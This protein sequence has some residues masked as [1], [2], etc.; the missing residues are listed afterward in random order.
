MAYKH[1]VDKSADSLKVPLYVRICFPLA[2]I[3]ILSSPLTIDILILMY[4]GL[5]PFLFIL[6]GTLCASWNRMSNPP[7]YFS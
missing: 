6:C 5:D 4:L 1:S 3:N 7:L 2:A